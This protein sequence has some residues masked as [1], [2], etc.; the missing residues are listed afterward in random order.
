MTKMVGISG[1]NDRMDLQN[2]FKNVTLLPTTGCVTPS[3][4]NVTSLEQGK[5]VGI[6]PGGGPPAE[7]DANSVK[8]FLQYGGDNSLSTQT[9]VYTVD[10][11]GQLKPS[12]I[13]M[14]PLSAVVE[15]YSKAKAN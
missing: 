11:M 1:V 14:A 8:G 13:Y 9:Q 10:Q 3:P 2:R 4:E 7:I 6:R 5:I 15:A 12:V